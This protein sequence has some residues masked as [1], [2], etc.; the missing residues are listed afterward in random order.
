MQQLA[1]CVSVSSL[2]DLHQVVHRTLCRIDNLQPELT[3][4]LRSVI[5]K[6]GKPCGL[7][8][9]AQGPR[10]MRSYA[11]WVGSENRVLFY[12][13]SGERCFVVVLS[14][15]PDPARLAA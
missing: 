10:L 9:Q 7:F 5:R 6:A 3:P 2:E 12:N 14:E 4:L 1:T 15:S 11:I 8:Y 13:T